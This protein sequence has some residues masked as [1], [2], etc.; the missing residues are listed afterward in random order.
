MRRAKRV[1]QAAQEDL[2]QPTC[3]EPI[4]Q[5][6][7]EDVREKTVRLLAQMLRQHRQPTPR[8]HPPME[9]DDE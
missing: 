5:Q 1:R 6:L 3:P 4:W 8:R 7:P 9:A 2:F